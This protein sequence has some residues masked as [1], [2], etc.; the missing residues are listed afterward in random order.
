MARRNDNTREELKK[1]AIQA[2]VNLLEE[3]G[4]AELSARKI[5]A[6]MGYTVGTLYNVFA[7]FEDIILHVN[8]ATLHEMHLQLEPLA[9][10]KKKAKERILAFA[11]CYG[12]YALNHSAR[13]NLLHNSPRSTPLPEWFR[14]EIHTVFAV[15]EQPLLELCTRHPADATNAAKVLWAGLHG[16]CSLSISQKLDAVQAGPMRELIGNFVTHY[17]DGL[18]G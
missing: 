9:K 10:S 16:I 3:S 1:M 12:D 6:R 15:V 2:S 5:A 4:V 13:W 14:S 11:Y 18:A 17:L 8:A 7:D